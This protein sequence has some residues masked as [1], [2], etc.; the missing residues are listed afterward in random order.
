VHLHNTNM[1][2]MRNRVFFSI[3]D[4]LSWSRITDLKPLT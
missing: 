1:F 2:H 3:K 4:I